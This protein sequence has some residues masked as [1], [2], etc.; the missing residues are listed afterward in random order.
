ML[1]LPVVVI[2]LF[3]FAS[4]YLVLNKIFLKA[5]YIDRL[6]FV[7]DHS[8]EIKENILKPKKIKPLWQVSLEKFLEGRIQNFP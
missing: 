8:Q 2:G 5:S 1:Y 7:E 3:L 6:Q 4:I